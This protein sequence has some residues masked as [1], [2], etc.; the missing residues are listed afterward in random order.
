MKL[1][2][3][4]EQMKP[5]A[6]LVGITNDALTYSGEGHGWGASGSGNAL[7]DT[8]VQFTVDFLYPL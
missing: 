2:E 8:A 5:Q 7:F 1:E 3:L 4:R 6:D